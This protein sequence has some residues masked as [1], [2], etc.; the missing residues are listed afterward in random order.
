[1][2]QAT[3]EPNPT[4]VDFS[5]YRVVGLSALMRIHTQIQLLSGVFIFGVIDPMAPGNMLLC[6][7]KIW[8]MEIS[9]FLVQLNFLYLE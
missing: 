7:R 1:V 9:I 4:S 3:S 6:L 2:I 5:P 8:I